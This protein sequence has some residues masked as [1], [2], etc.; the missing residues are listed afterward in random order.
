[1]S[2]KVRALTMRVVVKASLAWSPSAVR[3]TTKQTSRN[4][5]VCSKRYS[6]ATASLVLPVPVAMASK[7]RTPIIIGQRRLDRLNAAHLIIAQAESEVERQRGQ[8][9]AGGTAVDVEHGLQPVRRR[10]VDERA[11]A[12]RRIPCV[13]VPDARLRLELLEVRAPVC[14]E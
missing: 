7:Q 3:S 14:C 11:R 4:R 12:V 13:A 5:F 9:D 2:E 10:P 6:R 1:M 8:R